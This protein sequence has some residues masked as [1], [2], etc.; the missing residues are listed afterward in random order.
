MQLKWM[1][2][3]LMLTTYLLS[4]CSDSPYYEA[5]GTTEARIA[6]IT[7][8]L[9]LPADK[10]SALIDGLQDAHLFEERLGDGGGLGPT[11]YCRYFALSVQPQAIGEWVNMLSPTPLQQAENLHYSAPA[12]A[13]NWWLSE[14][15]YKTLTMYE[16]N[17]L[18]GLAGWV[19]VAKTGQV[20][21][22]I[23]TT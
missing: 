8:H 5:Q 22:F 10:K 3:F 15:T 17:A 19:G 12:Q 21:I 4:A 18:T 11:D 1:F 14:A 7:Q 2:S 23:C 16:A 9:K 20:Y 6:E 13:K